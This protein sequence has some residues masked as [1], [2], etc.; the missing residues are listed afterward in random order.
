MPRA[1]AVAALLL[2]A[3]TAAAL[4]LNRPE[5]EDVAAE[6]EMT[7]AVLAAAP[8]PPAAES[9]DAALRRAADSVLDALVR[10]DGPALA[11][12]AAP[13]GVRVSPSA[14]VDREA[15]RLLRPADLARLFTDR[16]VLR[17]GFAEGSGEPIALSGAAYVAQH[18]PAAEA[19]TQG[20]VTLDGSA[21][22]SNTVSNIAEAYPG[23]RVV[24][25]L[26]EPPPG[27]EDAEFRRLA[28]RLVFREVDG[29]PRLV[30]LVTD[31]WSP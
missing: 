7:A 22:R 29:Q 21:F 9:A 6:A 10:R 24:E 14:F 28:L 20:R 19:R 26:V 17:W 1:L 23:A 15:D 18:V 8:A 2:L 12:V 3:G 30:A 5:P 16:T 31:R 11:A 4:L 27:T 25:Y 13:E